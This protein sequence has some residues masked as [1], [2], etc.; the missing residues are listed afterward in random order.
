LSSYHSS[1]PS[2]SPSLVSLQSEQRQ[3]A[4]SLEAH[5]AELQQAIT[6]TT[7]MLHQPGQGA[8]SK[9]EHVY[10]QEAR[11][12]N[13]RTQT[14]RAEQ[15]LTLVHQIQTRMQQ[16]QSALQ[17]SSRPS[18]SSP[19][20]PF[21]ASTLTHSF[22]AL[23]QQLEHLCSLG[24]DIVQAHFFAQLQ[25]EKQFIRTAMVKADMRRVRE[26]VQFQE[27][28]EKRM[29]KEEEEE[30]ATTNQQPTL[31]SHS[32]LSLSVHTEPSL[33]LSTLFASL[34]SLHASDRCTR[35]L[36]T[37]L[38]RVLQPLLQWVS[39][40]GGLNQPLY[41]STEKQ[42]G[43]GR[44]LSIRLQEQETTPTMEGDI[45]QIL[46]TIFD[47]VWQQV[48]SSAPATAVPTTAS[49]A[50]SVPASLPPSMPS[51][52]SFLQLRLQP[53]ILQHICHASI[54]RC[55]DDLLTFPTRSS[56][57]L[58]EFEQQCLQRGLLRVEESESPPPAAP[59][60]GPITLFLASLHT[61]FQNGVQERV[62]LHTKSL[63]LNNSF[64]T[65]HFGRMEPEEE[66][67]TRREFPSVFYGKEAP[68]LPASPSA[69]SPSAS[70]SSHSLFL[71]LQHSHQIFSRSTFFAVSQ[72]TFAFV[73]MLYELYFEAFRAREK[74]GEEW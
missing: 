42:P 16:L 68:S 37:S 50:D 3:L 58:L 47:F 6:H 24:P 29:E 73:R 63:I 44:T 70:P 54:P 21:D 55:V 5:A 2:L 67:K 45:L 53:L 60:N 31:S 30:A 20:P 18:P 17:T 33:P 27:K 59:S 8:A 36:G 41:F 7:H 52:T 12:H 72:A 71:L 39:E 23:E 66:E 48:F 26:A 61:H 62:L 64:D 38:L 32:V 69:A 11:M 25:R 14:Q 9:L 34:H 56:S 51:L 35:Y 74:I 46:I 28:E 22:L 65:Q 57:K 10:E 1:W 49:S 43:G 13:Q 4:R 19:L 15:A 40:Q